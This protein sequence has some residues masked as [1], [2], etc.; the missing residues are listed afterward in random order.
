[1]TTESEEPSQRRAAGVD[2]RARRLPQARRGSRRPERDPRRARRTTTTSSSRTL[3]GRRAARA[4]RALHGVRR[5]VLPQRL[6]GQQPDPGLER[7]RLPRPLARGDRAAPPHEQLPRLHRAGSARRRARRRACSRSARATRSR[8]SRSSS[9]SSTAPGTRAGSRPQPPRRAD[10]PHGRGDRRRAR[11]GMACAQQ[12]RRAGHAVTRV[13]ARRGRRRARALRRAGL[14]DREAR[15][16]AA[17]RAARGRGRRVPLRRRRRRGRRRPTSCASSY[18]AVVI[19]T[20]ARVPRDLPVPGRELAGVHFAMDYLYQRNRFVAREL[21]PQMPGAP[22]APAG[23]DVITRRRQARDRDRRRRHRRRL[24]RERAPRGRRVGHADRADRRA[25]RLAPG[26]GHA[27]AALADEAAHP[28]RAQGGRRA[29]LRDLDHRVPRQRPRAGDPLGAELGRAR[30]SSSVAGHRGDA[31]G[32]ASCCSRWASSA[33]SRACSSSS[34]SSA[35]SAANAKAT[36]L[37]DVGRRRLRRRRRAPRPVA[38]RVGDQRGP[39]V[40]RRGR[41]LPR[42][43]SAAA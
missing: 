16:R 9:R 38:D 20:G 34:A 11:P 33:P 6:P 36:A 7:P 26:R 30:R 1:M 22:A 3:P 10:R 28:V 41:P 23:D 37:R 27:V 40:R 24:R 21:G 15:R 13:R 25:A 4:G 29:R 19:A 8:S 14:Q 43:R 5:A 42:R 17:R 12:L 32:R 2:G 35:T 39:P 31:P 18:D